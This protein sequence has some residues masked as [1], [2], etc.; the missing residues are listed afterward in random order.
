[1]KLLNC[2]NWSKI[3]AQTPSSNVL[4]WLIYVRIII[5]HLHGEPLVY[6][7]NSCS[8]LLTTWKIMILLGPIFC[9]VLERA[10]FKPLICLTSLR[11]AITTENCIHVDRQI[12][13]LLKLFPFAG[14]T[15]FES[16]KRKRNQHQ[17]LYATTFL[18]IL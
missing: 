11:Q 18:D 15:W 9:T 16:Q 1:M 7:K 5:T 10:T 8:L 13:T 12:N 2:N 4:I 17:L 6:L 14:S 3:W